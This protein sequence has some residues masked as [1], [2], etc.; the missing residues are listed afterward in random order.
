MPQPEER[1]VL[2]AHNEIRTPAGAQVLER[3]YSEEHV[4]QYVRYIV[5]KKERRVTDGIQKNQR[6]QR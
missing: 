6:D 2:A 1:I 3:A 5:R 4:G